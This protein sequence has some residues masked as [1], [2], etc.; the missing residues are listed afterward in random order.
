MRISHVFPKFVLNFYLFFNIFNLK[1]WEFSEETFENK[2]LLYPIEY[3]YMKRIFEKIRSVI[4]E[5]MPPQK[6]KNWK[7]DNKSISSSSSQNL[8]PKKNLKCLFFNYH[9]KELE[10][11]TNNELYE[12]LKKYF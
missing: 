9:K 11:K 8:K 5:K 10:E 6:S 12:T 2:L 4:H 1:D 7:T 3:Y